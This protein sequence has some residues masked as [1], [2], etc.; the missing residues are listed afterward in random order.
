MKAI[1]LK[2]EIKLYGKIPSSY[3]GKK[4]YVGG[5][6]LL[7]D[8]ELEKE[9]FFDVETPSI[10]YTVQE[11]GKLSFSKSKNKFV[12]AVKNKTWSE[13]ASDLKSNKI[14]QIKSYA[15]DLLS[16]TDWYITRQAEGIKDAPADIIAARKEIRDDADAEITKLNKLS[17]KAD[18]AKFQSKFQ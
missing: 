1:Q 5:F 14:L 7:S 13:S 4:H 2:D 8:S 9:G 3:N 12:Y 6:N 17:K 16:N 18:I 10:D 11:L 15:K